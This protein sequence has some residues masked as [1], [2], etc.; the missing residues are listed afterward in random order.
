[1]KRTI[2]AIVAIATLTL[3]TAPLAAGNGPGQGYGGGTLSGSAC[4]QVFADYLASLPLEQPDE[5]E[6]TSLVHMRQEE[7]LARDVYLTLQLQWGARI[8]ANI[9]RAEQKHMD[10]VK[11][12]LDRYGLE[13][14]V[15]DD[16]I[17]IFP[18]DRFVEL[19]EQ[20]VETGSASLQD[21]LMVGATI[22]DLDIWDLEEAILNEVDN[23]DIKAVYQNL[24][25]G[26]RNHMRAF[27]SQLALYDIEYSAQY[28]SAEELE[29][30]LSADPER[31]TILDADGEVLATCGNPGGNRAG[32]ARATSGRARSG[33]GPVTTGTGTGTCDGTGP[34]A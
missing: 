25:K 7:K 5:T 8:F 13:D 4:G 33:G 21:A 17:G 2:I 14:P 10:M 19:Y 18:D 31:G 12:I 34:G 9:A 1:M 32:G 26:S 23:E 6:V 27:A 15:T 28:I 11:T 20:L 3:G 30:I 22:E 29:T 24:W 16:T